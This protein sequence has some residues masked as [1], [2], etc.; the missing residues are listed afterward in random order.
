MPE[1]QVG[2]VHASQDGLGHAGR[3]VVD[4]PR[5][6]GHRVLA[7]ELLSRQQLADATVPEHGG[8]A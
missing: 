1:H 4:Q 8:P 5:Q 7:L 6:G 2:C 3:E